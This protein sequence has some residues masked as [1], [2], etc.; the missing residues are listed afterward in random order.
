MASIGS[1]TGGT[2]S[3][4]DHLMGTGEEGIR[5][6]EAKRLCGL[7]VYNKLDVDNRTAAINRAREQRII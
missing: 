4:F 7:H 2:R 5:N 3:L 6:S 1:G